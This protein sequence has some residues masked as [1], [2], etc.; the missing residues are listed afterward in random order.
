MCERYSLKNNNH[1]IIIIIT[2]TTTLTMKATLLTGGILTR[3]QKRII[4][5][6]VFH[7][8]RKEGRGGWREW[9]GRPDNRIRLCYRDL[10]GS[11]FL[12]EKDKFYFEP[13]SLFLFAFYLNIIT[14]SFPFFIQSLPQTWNSVCV[15]REEVPPPGLSRLT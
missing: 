6:I 13:D 14:F 1:H 8:V 12:N 4:Y 11:Y 2:T 5:F 15:T 10:S 3:G 9:D 7:L